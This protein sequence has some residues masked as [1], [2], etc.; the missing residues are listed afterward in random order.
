MILG[1]ELWD[2]EMYIAGS[3]VK[4]SNNTFLLQETRSISHS[5][6]QLYHLRQQDL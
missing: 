6:H 1:H 5:I 3:P 2:L 4:N